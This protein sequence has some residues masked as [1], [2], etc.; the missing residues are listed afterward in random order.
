MLANLDLLRCWKGNRSCK[1]DVYLLPRQLDSCFFTEQVLAHAEV[2]EGNHVGASQRHEK[3][4]A[5]QAL[6]KVLEMSRHHAQLNRVSVLTILPENRAMTRTWA[7]LRVTG[8]DPES[9][10]WRKG[11]QRE[12]GSTSSMAKKA[13]SE[14]RPKKNGCESTVVLDEI[15][16]L[17]TTRRV[18]L[19]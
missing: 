1:T 3:E 11:R 13:M 4:L 15:C 16:S 6:V 19:S 7:I 2:L 17:P 10:L 14:W 18:D 5:R 8:G 9:R 12:S